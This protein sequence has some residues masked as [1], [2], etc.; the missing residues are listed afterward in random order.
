MA[1]LLPLDPAVLNGGQ[2]ALYDKIMNGPRGQVAGPL[3][4]MVQCS[5]AGDLLQELGDRLRFNGV[6][7]GKLRE[8][9]I[10]IVARFWSA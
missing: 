1:R 4:A 6:L 5:A 7:P 9:A 3:E 2:K 10:L 8:L